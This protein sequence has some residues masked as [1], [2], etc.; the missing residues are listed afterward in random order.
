[1]RNNGLRIHAVFTAALAGVFALAPVALGDSG[2]AEVPNVTNGK[3][4]K[5]RSTLVI[6][7][8][9]HFPASN[10]AKEAL[11][12]ALMFDPILSG[13]Q[14]ISCATCHH[15]FAGT[16]DGLSLPV[17]EG[18]SGTGVARSLPAAPD[19]DA[20][21]E[22]VPRNAPAIWNAGAD[23][24]TIMFH[25]GRVCVDD[26]EPSGFISPAGAN[27]PS[28]LDSALAAQAMFPV[29]SGTEM[30]GQ[31]GENAI[32][33]AAF[34]GN[35]AGAG[36]VWELLA[37]RLQGVPEYVTM[38]QA[39][40]ADVTVAGDIT[41]VHAANAIA[42][43]EAAQW[44]STDSDF[45]RWLAGDNDAMSKSAK[46]G[47][48]L[49]YGK[50]GCS[51]CH[52]GTY[53]TDHDFHCISMPQIGAGKGDNAPGFADGHDDFGRFRE[54][55]DAA[56]MYAFRT[57]S[58]RNTV[59]NSPWGHAGAYNSLEAV[60]RHHLD[61]VASLNAYDQAQAVLPSRADLD[62]VDFAV[63][64]TPARVAEIAA[65][66]ELAPF[67]ATDRQVDDMVAF[68]Y[69]LTGRA[70]MDDRSAVPLSLPSGLPVGD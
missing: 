7:T 47:M 36:G 29:T 5:V 26:T 23:Q 9:A 52:A 63:M 50:A 31:N 59:I 46:R 22:R 14:N 3:L 64:D 60:I 13:N 42:A 53:Q 25:D 41:Y 17:G 16:G 35:L 65:A 48:K 38:F 32:A 61:P 55:G 11:G 15:P 68:M 21:V 43:F 33:T 39:A 34:N 57:P 20:P 4:K 10:A 40:Y 12:K 56:E 49:F 27:L 6:P 66:N 54:S 70:A 51:E 8:D 69:A 44:R 30:A 19:T 18:A 1:M 58:L 67:D 62:A 37:T 28:G 24:F 45:D 2:A